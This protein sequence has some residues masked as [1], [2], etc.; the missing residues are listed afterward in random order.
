MSDENP[1]AI[2]SSHLWCCC[3]LVP[4]F[5]VRWYDA[6]DYGDLTE[7]E[8][9]IGGRRL[10]CRR[11]CCQN[12]KELLQFS[13]RGNGGRYDHACEHRTLAKP[14][15][16]CLFFIVPCP[17]CIVSSFPDMITAARPCCPR[18]EGT[19]SEHARWPGVKRA[20]KKP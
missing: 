8:L 10:P 2:W 20:G 19:R 6:L 5:P 16:L 11:A 3:S 4:S 12:E 14:G 18:V 1:E 17:L 15:H 13:Q 9:T 7:K